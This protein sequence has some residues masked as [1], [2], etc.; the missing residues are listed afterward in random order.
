MKRL[1]LALAL[2]LWASA[3][4]AASRFWVGGTGTWDAVTTTNWA[5]TTGGAGG[6]SVPTAA[7]SVTFDANSGG[8]TVTLNFGGTIT[9]INLT[10]GAFTG[11]FENS[12]NNNNITMTGS[13]SGTGTATRT[14][15]FGTATYSVAGNMNFATTTNLTL[16]AASAT[17]RFSAGNSQASFGGKSWGTVIWTGKGAGGLG[18]GSIDNRL[19]DGGNTF[20][21]WT[22]DNTNG[23]IVLGIVAGGTNTVTN[24]IVWVG[25]RLKPI[26]IWSLTPGTVTNLVIA[27][28]SSITWASLWS[29]A[30]SG[31]A[32]SATNT[33]DLRANTGIT[34]TG[35]P[36]DPT[37]TGA[38]ILG[39]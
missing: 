16:S 23:V 36:A 27:S 15:N 25:S 1:A 3:S 28:G 22:M 4:E 34:I 33:F 20:G 35:P 29:I 26:E 11:T 19:N 14:F 8:G 2:C 39:G 9:I 13:W 32:I 10:M 31:A 6:Q 30:F 37:G 21:T 12:T 17:V 18:T 24:P 38:C 7:D 5:A